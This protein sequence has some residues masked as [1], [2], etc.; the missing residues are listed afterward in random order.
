MIG[1]SGMAGCILAAVL[2]AMAWMPDALAGIT[3]EEFEDRLAHAEH[4]NVTAPWQ[5]SSAVMDELEPY[6][7]QATGNQ[8]ARFR[9]LEARNRALDGDL[10]QGLAILERLFDEPL[11]LE[12]RVR[13]L[14]R[15]VNLATLARR[16][17][18]AFAHLSQALELVQ[19][20]GSDFQSSMLHSNAAYIYAQVGEIERA[21]DYGELSTSQ[22]DAD[23]D[24]RARCIAY[25]RLGYVYKVKGA[26]EE[27]RDRY[28]RA[29]A[30]CQESDD[31]LIAGVAGYG[32]ADL[33][34]E[35]EE[36]ERS[37]AL[38]D[39]S[40]ERIEQTGYRSGMAEARL[41]RARLHKAR[42]EYG[43]AE[44]MLNLAL[45]QL[46]ANEVWEYLAEAHEMLAGIA[47]DRGQTDLALEHFQAH[48]DARER[49][50]DM[51]RSRHLAFLQVEFDTQSRD[52]ELALLREQAAV[53][54]LEEESSRQQARFRYFGYIMASILVIVLGLLLRNAIK[55][56]Q[57][58]R[59][60]SRRDGLTKLNNHTR[61]FELA[62]P[63]FEQAQREG[64]SYT[65]V[66]GDIDHFKQV[67]DRHGH[68]AGDE[69]LR[70]V[71]SHL[72]A[73]F[74][75]HGI[76]G[77][78]GG[79]EFAV[80]LPDWTEE[81]ACELVNQARDRL[82]ESRIGKY[83][84]VVSMSFGVAAA[85]EETG[86]GELREQADLALYRAKNA[87]RNRVVMAHA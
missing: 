17:E 32:L 72:Q 53:R 57:H 64:R 21:V 4:L 62:V 26:A 22:A 60:L 25:Q 86:L 87:G 6:L 80:A 8:Y 66:L 54:S 85:R 48:S 34:R 30:L 18:T 84:V 2:A 1:R 56:R 55:E 52:Q 7:D 75:R 47:R 35:Q 14:Q 46:E 71:A 39:E 11:D 73:I 5:E 81:Q 23:G 49:F 33:L 58:F 79:E 50:L 42:E 29:L 31:D 69:V 82:K 12:Y 40:M 51:D 9:L 83:Q 44:A 36:F 65:L 59:R 67:N 16:Y 70:Q 19:E 45:D 61:F 38:F 37:E 63:A 3:P 10:P 77:R 20:L 15:A 28:R 41:Y 68:L 78:I 74:D 27:S 76:L 24:L 13:A 43:E